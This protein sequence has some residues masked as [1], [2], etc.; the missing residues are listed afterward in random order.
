MS[1]CS[2]SRAASLATDSQSSAR[3]CARIASARAPRALEQRAGAAEA[4]ACRAFADAL[5]ELE[6]E[7]AAQHLVVAVRPAV[8]VDR[9]R[10]DLPLG[11]RGQVGV[12]AR[13]VEQLVAERA[14]QL[15]EHAGLQQEVRQLGLEIGEHV[16]REV[17][18]RERE[19]R[20]EAGQQAPSLGRR[21]TAAGEVEEL[22][23]GGPALGP[24]RE[25]REVARRQRLAVDLPEELLD[26]PRAEA[27]IVGVQLQEVAGDEQA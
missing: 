11:E 9:A 23:A 3:H 21:A 5:D 18:A 2:P 13:R 19:V 22:E 7:V 4:L 12:R 1:R 6:L 15:A 24:A 10:E 20:A 17:L 27:E 14:R 8:L 16:A 25:H 26:L